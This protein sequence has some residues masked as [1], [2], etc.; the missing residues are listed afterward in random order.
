LPTGLKATSSEPPLVD[1]L[2]P[3][4]FCV[5][6]V[7]LQVA[8]GSGGLPSRGSGEGARPGDIQKLNPK[9]TSC[10]CHCYQRLEAATSPWTHV[11]ISFDRSCN[12]YLM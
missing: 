4:C 11:G 3:Q 8:E 7:I 6:R 2:D 10:K 5:H 12:D 1:A 9:A